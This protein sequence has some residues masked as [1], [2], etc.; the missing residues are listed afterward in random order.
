LPSRNIFEI[1]LPDLFT[2]CESACPSCIH[3]CENRDCR[4][5]QIRP[6]RRSPTNPCKIRLHMLLQ[7]P[8]SPI[9]V[10]WLQFTGALPF[11]IH[12]N[13]FLLYTKPSS[14]D[15]SRPSSRA[16][17]TATAHICSPRV[18]QPAQCD[19]DRLTRSRRATAERT[20]PFELRALTGRPG[21]RSD[22]SSPTMCE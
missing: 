9:F 3:T 13:C 15:S 4:T 22:A 5:M 19:S 10:F 20:P 11:H 2:D 12:P 6:A 8:G 7:S 21:D 14:L 18:G 1:A 17:K 16:H